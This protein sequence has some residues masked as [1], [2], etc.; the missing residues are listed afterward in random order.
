MCVYLLIFDCEIFCENGYGVEVDVEEYFDNGNVFMGVDGG[1]FV[2]EVDW[3][4]V[5][6]GRGD[7][8]VGVCIGWGIGCED[9]GGDVCVGVG[10][11]N[12][13]DVW[14]KGG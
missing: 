10:D 9:G 8:D 2:L 13:G 7:V 14:V 11:F 4:C 12:D 1:E 5:G 6:G 3:G